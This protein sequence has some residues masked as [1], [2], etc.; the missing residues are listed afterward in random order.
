MYSYIRKILNIVNFAIL[1]EAIAITVC[2]IIQ[3]LT[4]QTGFLYKTA[5]F[6]LFFTSLWYK[7]S[8]FPLVGHKV[9]FK[10]HIPKINFFLPS[11]V[12]R[13]FLFY[14]RQKVHFWP[15]SRKIKFLEW[16]LTVEN[17]IFLL[18]G[19]KVAF[20]A[21]LGQ[22][23]QISDPLVGKNRVQHGKNIDFT[24]VVVTLAK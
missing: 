17:Y 10:L 11:C 24:R 22:T 13:H 18:E 23:N 6:T 8:I 9:D 3:K 15:E 16:E 1:N 5:F 21:P 12:I 19:H 4:A 2:N 14:R 7:K 20:I